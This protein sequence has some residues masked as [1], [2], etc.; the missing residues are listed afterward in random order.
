MDDAIGSTFS[1]GDPLSPGESLEISAF[2]S[3]S[4]FRTHRRLCAS[5]EE[6]RL[7]FEGVLAREMPLPTDSEGECPA[8]LALRL[9]LGEWSLCRI[10]GEEWSG[11]RVERGDEGSLVSSNGSGSSLGGVAGVGSRMIAGIPSAWAVR[12]LRRSSRAVWKCFRQYTVLRSPRTRSRLTRSVTLSFFA[13]RVRR[14]SILPVSLQPLR[15]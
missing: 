15:M 10:S 6:S 2:V 9:G 7:L 12:I 3:S 14:S 4:P 11:E 8:A 5:S 13:R 1:P